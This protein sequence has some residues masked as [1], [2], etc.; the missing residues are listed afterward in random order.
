[1]NEK[2]FLHRFELDSSL[3]KLKKQREKI[4]LIHVLDLKFLVYLSKQELEIFLI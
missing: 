2:I 4:L 1:M 3:Q